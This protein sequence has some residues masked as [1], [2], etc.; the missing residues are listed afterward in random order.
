MELIVQIALGVLLGGL[1]L[2][3]VLNFGAYFLI[4]LG[5]ISAVLLVLGAFT[6]VFLSVASAYEQ[7]N[8]SFNKFRG[9]H[10]PLFRRLET[11]IA[12]IGHT[13]IGGFVGYVIASACIF[14]IL[15]VTQ[16]PHLSIIG[17]LFTAVAFCFFML[18]G[19]TVMRA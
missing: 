4:G 12:L 1:L 8:D 11:G 6:W 7:A 2:Y 14:L 3:A 17:G 10:S 5:V 19:L 13:L 15:L 9:R 16:N 18:V